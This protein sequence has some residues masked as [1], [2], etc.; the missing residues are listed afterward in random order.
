MFDWGL[1]AVEG[2]TEAGRKGREG[3]VFLCECS[4]RRKYVKWGEGD[5]RAGAR[6]R[7][8]DEEKIHIC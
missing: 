7:C 3:R 5:A 2:E 8:I 6:V 4:R 1:V